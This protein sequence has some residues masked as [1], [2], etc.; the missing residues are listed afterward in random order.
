MGCL[1]G[2]HVPPHPFAGVVCSPPPPS[3]PD[4]ETL[5]VR[6]TYGLHPVFSCYRHVPDRQT[7]LFSPF[8]ELTGPSPFGFDN[9][10][11]LFRLPLR[12]FL[13]TC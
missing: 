9:R 4:L 5:S 6:I 3:V 13:R 2:P 12:R 10:V 11:P 1:L 8:S 7:A